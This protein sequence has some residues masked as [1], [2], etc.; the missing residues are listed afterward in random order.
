MFSREDLEKAK[1]A[2]D[3]LAAD[4]AGHDGEGPKPK[5]KTDCP[6]L[7][8]A[9]LFVIA[10]LLSGALEVDAIEVDRDQIIQISLEGS[11]KR[12]TQLDRIM[13]QIGQMPFEQVVRAIVENSG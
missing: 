3:R 12:K 6:K 1:Q 2:V 10:G 5:K 9:T 7:S 11:L 4:E 8:P 13:E